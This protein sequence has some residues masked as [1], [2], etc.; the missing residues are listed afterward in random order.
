ML[1]VLPALGHLHDLGLLFC[2]LKVDNII[3][4]RHAVKLIDLGGVY[5]LGIPK[6][7]CS[8]PSATRRQRSR[9]SGRRSRLTYSRL[10]EPSRCCARLSEYQSTRFTLPPQEQLPCSQ[11]YDSLYRFLL[12]ATSTEPDDRFQ[13]AEEM[14]DQLNQVLGEIAPNEDGR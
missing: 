2:D 11:R 5:R 10:P 9:R 4:T 6:A 3:Q 12:K 8:G 14:A 13:S 1:E 7:L